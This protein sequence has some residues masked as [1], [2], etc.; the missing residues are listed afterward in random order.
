MCK[1]PINVL[2]NIFMTRLQMVVP[3]P[4]S[5]LSPVHVTL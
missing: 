5:P 3:H 1:M 2:E 4:C